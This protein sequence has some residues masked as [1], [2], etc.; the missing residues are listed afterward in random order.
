M[1]TLFEMIKMAIFPPKC[2]RCGRYTP[3]DECLCED[4]RELWE[5][6]KLEKCCKCGKSHVECLCPIY[7]EESRLFGVFHLAEYKK[8]TVAAELVYK[9]K[10]GEHTPV[11]SFLAKELYE[12]LCDRDDFFEAVITFVPRRRDAVKRY[13][14][15]QAY[16]LAKALCEVSDKE[17]VSLFTRQGNRE[18][19]N[20]NSTE[21]HKNVRKSY[22]LKDGIEDEIIG[23]R[24]FIVDD[25]ITTGATVSYLADLLLDMGALS[26]SAVSV[27][28]RT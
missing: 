10:D 2:I 6:E 16:E 5:N 21:R 15:D 18:Q 11:N 8:E 17:L 19:K 14:S 13:G 20:M 4:C 9:I 24:I 1:S 26:V 7:D 22:F 25:I 3:P 12:R 27:A 28:R 23:K